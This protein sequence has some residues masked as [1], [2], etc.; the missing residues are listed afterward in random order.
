[1][2]GPGD[3]LCVGEPGRLSLEDTEW[4]RP[5]ERLRLL[6]ITVP[7]LESFLRMLRLL[8]EQQEEE[9]QEEQEEEEQEEKEQRLVWR[10]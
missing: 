5:E 10:L 8:Q 1:V 9:E 7:C 2:A 6:C 3:R 4:C